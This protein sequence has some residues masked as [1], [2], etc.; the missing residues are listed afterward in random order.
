MSGCARYVQNNYRE[1][2]QGNHLFYCVCACLY[3]CVTWASTLHVMSI[4]FA[5]SRVHKHPLGV[6][7]HTWM[8]TVP[9]HTFT[10]C[11]QCVWERRAKFKANGG[12]RVTG[13]F[14]CQKVCLHAA[15][16]LR[17]AICFIVILFACA[18]GHAKCFA[19][20]LA[21][22][23]LH[24]VS[25]IKI[26]REWYFFTS[27]LYSFPHRSYRMCACL[28]FVCFTDQGKSAHRRG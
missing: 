5:F 13:Y 23:W 12:C 18:H 19:H 4:H 21:R 20:L 6:H 2:L 26:K 25:L 14:D 7:S 11:L 24:L 27:T 16:C 10:I 3:F 9:L 28:T 22:R 8:A 15:G 17:T 1:G